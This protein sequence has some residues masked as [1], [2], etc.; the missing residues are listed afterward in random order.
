MSGK[1]K[2]TSVLGFQ[3]EGKAREKQEHCGEVEKEN[4]GQEYRKRIVR[5][6]AN[7]KTKQEISV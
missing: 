4:G 2:N 1:G 7:S 5:Q 6:A 3:E